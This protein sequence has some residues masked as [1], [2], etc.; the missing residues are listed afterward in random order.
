MNYKYSVVMTMLVWEILFATMLMWG[1]KTICM[2]NQKFAPSI[3]IV[4][5]EVITYTEMPKRI[6]AS[7]FLY[8]QFFFQL[9]HSKHKLVINL[10]NFVKNWKTSII[11]DQSE[12]HEEI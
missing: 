5:F 11:R 6:T 2:H 1:E 10:S 12:T 4:W 8:A 9:H 7:L 3:C